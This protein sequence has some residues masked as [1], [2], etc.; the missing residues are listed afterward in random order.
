MPTIKIK[1]PSL[2]DYSMTYYM[3]GKS[4][5]VFHVNFGTIGA[6]LSKTKNVLGSIILATGSHF[7]LDLL[8]ITS[9]AKAWNGR[10]KFSVVLTVSLTPCFHMYIL[11]LN[12]FVAIY[13]CGKDK[14]LTNTF[15]QTYWQKYTSSVKNLLKGFL[16]V[17]YF[18]LMWI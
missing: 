18:I 4:G 1:T 8:T 13:P 5:W 3:I 11:F 15:M 6:T 7:W 10:Y 12:A 9:Y 2:S 14:I 16:R 17:L